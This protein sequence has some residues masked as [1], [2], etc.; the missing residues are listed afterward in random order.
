M[1]RSRI[2]AEELEDLRLSYDIPSSVLLR[3]LGRE[4]RADDPHEG[5]VAIYEPAIQQGLRLPMHPFFREV[6]KDWNL[7]P[8]QITPNGWGQM[9]A[10]YLLWV[11]AEARRNLTP[12][13][14]ESI[15]RPCQSL[16]WYN[17]S[18]RPGQKWRTA[19][20][21]PNKVHNW[22]ER[23]FFVG[24]DWEFI[25]EDLLPHVSIPRR[26]E[27]L[28]CGKPPIS[29][30]NQ[31]ELRSKW[32]KLR[33]LSSEFRSLNNLL[34]DDNLLASCGLMGV[35]VIRLARPASGEG[36]SAQA[37]RQEA[38]GPLQEVQDAA[39]SSIVNPLRPE[40]DDNVLSRLPSFSNIHI[41]STASRDKG[42]KVA[43]GAEEAPSQKRKAPT[44]TEGLMRNAHKAR[45][46][47]EGRRSSP[48][49][50]GEPEGA[51][52]PVPSVGQNRRIRISERRE[53]LSASVME[54]L[55]AHPWIVA[56]S[57][58]RYWTLS[59][60]K[61]AE[62]AT[63]LEWL[64]LAE[65]NLVRGLVLAKDIFSAFASFDA[66]D[67]KSKKL[68]E[69]LKAM[70]LEKVQ[71]ESDKRAL[72]FKL[73]LKRAAEAS[74]KRAE[75]VQSLAEDQTLTVETALAAANS[76]LEAAATDNERSLSAMKLELEKIKAERAD[77]EARAVEAYQ[78]AFVNTPEYQDLAHRLMTVGGEQLVERIVEAHPEWDLSFLREAPPKFMYPRLI[79]TIPVG[80]TLGYERYSHHE[81]FDSRAE[82]DPVRDG[83]VGVVGDV[84]R[85]VSVPGITSRKA[86]EVMAGSSSPKLTALPSETLGQSGKRKTAMGDGDETAVPGQ[87]AGGEIEKSC[88]T[89]EGNEDIEALRAENNDLYARL[90]FSDDARAR[91]TYDVAKVQTIQRTCLAAQRKAETQLR[92]TQSIIHAK[93]KELNE[94]LAELSKAKKQLASHGVPGYANLEDPSGI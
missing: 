29:K 49:L 56:A 35:L 32:D 10:S 18:S 33:A 66:E 70:G 64:Q 40:V 89:A 92:S 16:G 15:Y 73:N 65:V 59:W 80:E 85:P 78:D 14:F 53:E 26:F 41:D 90:A 77:A 83:A 1:A 9:V 6:L 31:W 54:M 67:S 30:W 76:S 27:E 68:V 60:E 28:D 17:V 7:A 51:G 38:S 39:P 88:S 86:P 21:S 34:K 62:E 84:S 50:D 72:Q 71:L 44:A 37:F 69:D 94:T 48:S 25:P 79:Q 63:I 82:P 45:R 22:K 93:D 74:Q 3:A 81:K 5:F 75:E 87:D 57:V 52:N 4:E 11:V 46:T 20:D 91:A 61:V 42:K 13:E 8:C 36:S 58:H 47:E 2:T 12:R 24:R 19:T 55:P 43:E 23:F